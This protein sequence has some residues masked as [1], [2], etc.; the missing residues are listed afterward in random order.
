MNTD[1]VVPHAQLGRVAAEVHR[2]RSV[3]GEPVVT[4]SLSRLPPAHPTSSLILGPS[5]AREAA[6]RISKTSPRD[7][8]PGLSAVRNR[9]SAR[10]GVVPMIRKVELF[11]LPSCSENKRSAAR[12]GMLVKVCRKSWLSGGMDSSSPLLL[13]AGCCFLTS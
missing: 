8:W 10:S 5:H 2:S 6:R 4:R 11:P 1:S 3:G 13:L 9:S 7:R 12:N